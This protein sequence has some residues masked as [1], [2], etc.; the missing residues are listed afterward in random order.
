MIFFV[1]SVA[2]ATPDLIHKGASNLSWSEE[3]LLL[4]GFLA[5]IAV[6]GLGAWALDEIRKRFQK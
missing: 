6:V 5:A 1:P 2:Y 3:L 4:L